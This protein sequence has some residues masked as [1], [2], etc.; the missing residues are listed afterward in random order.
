MKKFTKILILIVVAILLLAGSTAL[1]ADGPYFEPFSSDANHASFWETKF[2]AQGAS[3][4]E[5]AFSGPSK[6]LTSDHDLLVLKSGAGEDANAYWFDV[7]AGE[8]YSHPS[9]K[10]ISHIIVCDF[11]KQYETCD[12]TT[13]WIPQTPTQ[14][15]L[16][17][18]DVIISTVY[19]KLDAV[20]QETVCARR[21][22]LDRVEYK[23]CSKQDEWIAFG[24]PTQRELANGDI[25]TSQ[26]YV[27]FDAIDGETICARRVN[28]E[29]EEYTACEGDTFTVY[30]EWSSWEGNNEQTRHRIVTVFDAKTQE[31][32]GV[33]REE[34]SKCEST[35]YGEL[36][37]YARPNGE[38]VGFASWDRK[39]DGSYWLP[40]TGTVAKCLGEVTLT[41]LESREITI[42][43]HGIPNIQV[44]SC[45]NA[46]PCAKLYVG[47]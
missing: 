8:T 9:G 28:L 39:D 34:E 13:G 22:E 6:T 35:S 37:Y 30:G 46:A 43:C 18:G 2:A 19:L 12:D 17:N 29:R 25:I 7:K 23:T 16:P 4:S 3:C 10:D 45:T 44:I 32:C 11:E 24:E 47:N 26:V 41:N 14:R 33:F 36:F 15:E 21:V 38:I 20:D 42:D 27:R 5:V 31:Q 40:N 1:A